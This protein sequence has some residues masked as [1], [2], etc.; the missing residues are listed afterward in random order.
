MMVFIFIG[1]NTTINAQSN[2]YESYAILNSN[3]GGNTY[4]DLK[5]NTGNT[6][7]NGANLGTFNSGSSLILNGAQNKVFKCN[8]DNITDGKLYYRIYTTTGTAGTFI[9]T[10]LFWWGPGD[11]GPGDY[12]VS[13]PPYPCNGTGQHWQ[14]SGANINVLNGLCPGDYYL[15]IYTTADFTYTGVPGFGTHKADN[16]GNNYKATFTV[17]GT[18]TV[19]PITPTLANITGQCTATATAP[20]TTDACAGTIIGTTS[21]ALTY[22]TQGTHIIHW[23]FND[24]NGQSIVVN[25]NVIIDDTVAPVTPTLADITGQCT[26][27]APIPTTTDACS[28]TI[29]GTTSDALTYS[30]QGTHIIH[31][32]FNDGNGQSIVV[33][34]NVIIDDT[35]DPVIPTLANI[36]GQCTATATAPTTTDACSGTIIGTTSDALTYSTQ[37]T[38]IIHWTFN[39]GNG[40]SIVVNQNVIIDDTVAPVT[41]TLAD[42]TGQCTAT[43]PIPTTTDACSGTIIGTTSDALTY[44]TQGTHIIHWT[45]NDGNGQSI[46]VNQNVIIDDTVKPTL[47][48]IADKNENIVTACN[49]TIPDYTSL[50]TAADNCT[51]VGS[52]SKTQSPASGT[53]ISGNNATQLITI[54]AN[55]GN[56]NTETT[57]FTI[58]LKDVTPPT[59]TCPATATANTNNDGAGNC[60]TIVSLGTPTVS[61]NCTSVGNILKTAKVGGNTI[62]PSTYLFGI[63]NTTVVWTATDQ[64]GNVSIPCNQTVTVIDNENPTIN[65]PANVQLVANAG[66]TATT[67]LVTP[68]AMDNCSVASVTND[69][70]IAFPLGNT[71]VTWTVTDTSGNKATCTQIVTVL[72][73]T[74]PTAICKNIS[75][76]LNAA[77]TASITAADINDNSTDN[78]GIASLVA[79]KTSFDCT[80]LGANSVTLTV[81]DT[82]GNVSYCTA[83]VTIVDVTLPVALCKS[84]TL[85]LNASGNAT[86]LATD[87]D[88]GSSDNCSFTRTISKSSFN[89]SNIGT[90]TVQLTI[91]DTSGNFTTCNATVTVVDPIAPVPQ[92]KNVILN[93]DAAGNA[94]LLATDIDNGSTDNCGIATRTVSPSSFTCANVGNNTVT[95]TVKDASN[96]TSTCTATVTIKDLIPPT[97]ICKAATIYLNSAGIATLTTADV[98]NGSSDNCGSVTLSLSKTSFD[99]SNRGTNTV[100]LTVTDTAGNSSTC[101][102]TVTVIDN[103]PPVA[104]CKNFTLVLAANGTGTLLPANINNGSSDNCGITSMTLSK[105]NFTCTDANGA[106][107]LVTL[108]VTDAS[109]NSSTCTA[110]VTVQTTL[111]ISSVYLETCGARF[112][113]NVSGGSGTYSYLWDVTSSTVKPFSCSLFGLGSN[114]ANCASPYY[115]FV[116]NIIH[117]A[118]LT[119]NDSNGCKVSKTFT[120]DGGAFNGSTATTNV[121]AC[122]GQ[123]ITY[124]SSAVGGTFLGIP[125]TYNYGWDVTGGT[126]ISGGGS[127]NNTVTVNWGATGVGKVSVTNTPSL[128]GSF[129]FSVDVFNVTVNPLPTPSFVT[130]IATPVCPQSPQTYTLTN[131]FATHSWTVTGGTVTAGGDPA[132]NFVTVKWG[133]GATGTVS[134]T[135]TNPV[136]SGGCSSTVSTNVAIVDIIPPT[137]TCPA[138]VT[139]NA[140]TGL[141]YATGVNLGT[142]PTGND[143]CGVASVTNNA[144]TLFPTG[145]YPV[146]VHTITWTVTD[147]KGLTANCTQTVTVT[148]NQFPVISCPT[149]VS[150]SIL[151]G[152]NRSITIVNPTTSDNCGVTK[153]TWTM[154]GA[155]VANSS[156][157]GINN[158]GTYTFNRGVTTITYT[159][160]DNS[161]KSSSCSFTVTV[162]DTIPPTITCPSNINTTTN[163]ACTATG[164]ALGTPTTADNCSV[165]SVT[166]NAPVAFPIGTTIVTWTVTDVAGNTASCTQTVTVT[167]ATPPTIACPSNI[168]TTTAVGGCTRLV[169]VP[170][171]TTADNCSVASISWIMFGATTATGINAIGNYTFNLG[172]TTVQYTVTDSAN[173]TANCSF[174][175]TVN[176]NQPPVLSCPTNSTPLCADSTGKYTKT[177][178]SWNATATD[179]C[180]T[181]SSLTYTLT[182]STTGSGTS[183]DGVAFNVGTTTVTWTATDTIGNTSNC[184]FAVNII[185]LPSITTQPISQLD[186]EGSIVNFSVVATGTG[187][188]YTWQRKL[189]TDASFITIPIESNVSYPS[190]GEIRLANVDSTLSPDGTQYQVIIT[191]SSGCSITSAAATLS[192]NKITTL[193]PI[194]TAVTQ[195]YGTNYSYTVSTSYPANVISY[196]W[197]S[198]VVS[199]VW[200]DVVNGTHFLGAQTETLQIINGTPAESAAYRVYITFDASGAD[201]NVNS[202]SRSRSITFLPEVTAPV[203]TIIQ[204]SCTVATGSVVLSGLPASGTWTLTRTGTS[205]A[206]TTGTGTS[207]TISGLATG[208]YN[209]T[210]FDGTCTS[211]PANVVINVQP[212]TP[213]VPTIDAYTLPSFADN[214]GTITLGNLPSGNWVGHQIKDGVTTTISGTGSP[215]TLTGLSNGSYEFEV[216]ELCI[217]PR[218]TPT[219]LTTVP[220]IPAVSPATNINCTGFTANWPATPTATA[221]LL[222][223]STD[224]NFATFVSGY[225]KNVGN[226]L[227]Y[228][229]TGMP[230]GPLYYRIRAKNATL[231]SLYSATVTV[232]PLINT[233]SGTWSLGTPPT[234]IGTQ[235]LVFNASFTA[236]TDLSGCSCTVNSGDVIIKSGKILTITNGVTV[237]SPGTLT[238]EDT[239]SLVQI[240]NT[241]VNIGNIN[242]IRNFTGGE[243]DYTYWSSPVALQNLQTL[244]PNTKLD[245]FFYFNS[246]LNDWMQ[247]DPSTT[248]MDA[249]KGYI[250]RGVPPPPGPPVGF[251]TNTFIGRPNNGSYSLTGVIADRSYLLGNPYPSALD[252]DTFLVANKDVLNG[253]LYFWTHNTPIAI[254]TPDPG[255]GIWAYSGNDYAVYNATGGVGAAPPDLDPNTGLPYPSQALSGGKIPTGKIAAGQGFF[256]STKGSISGT[257]I[258][259]DNAMRVGVGGIT[260][261]NSQFFKTKNPKAKTNIQL[262]KHR[263]WLDLTNVEGAF[264]QTLI[265]YVTDATNGYEDRFD[266]ESYDGNDFLDFY[267]ILQDKNLVIQGR[268]LPFDEND[269]V[270]LGYRVAVG[271]TFT[272]KIGQKDGLLSNQE[273]FIEDKLT[274]TVVNLVEENYTFT[275][276][277]GTFDDRFVLKY[278]DKTLSVEDL[279]TNDGIIA[280]YSNNYKTLIIRNNLKD[281]TVNS[282]TLYNITGQKIANWEVKGR[283]QSSIQ[284]PIKN[285]PAEIYIVKI[286]TTQG[287]FSKKIIVK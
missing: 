278:T 194:A 240:N 34:Q 81:T 281:T 276:T 239:S 255:S 170:S 245:K 227:T 283:E 243:F 233:Y 234:T 252:A 44:S 2:I 219:P 114:T 222:D 263:V 246:S 181:I 119:V 91:T 121:V 36:I 96:N 11:G 230:A 145:Q 260:G 214:D 163:T 151:T 112:V 46:V 6:D 51:A 4:Y 85:N 269:E 19:A 229:L 272:M 158:V 228:S 58:T 143:N 247:V 5:A 159:A 7:F 254:G 92:C 161:G 196:Q 199:G 264:K 41:P 191:N 265:G 285:L 29:I 198:S 287:E 137:I 62:N 211:L 253:T 122:V 187:L 280:L 53:V 192:I 150:Q 235:N 42:I 154:T 59:I 132:D 83:T 197:K 130:P 236:N 71:T 266:G 167:D 97:A 241:A 160:F 79:S 123:T 9:L 186:C 162:T 57:S 136:A 141:C 207:T 185:G 146:G 35:T 13:S 12:A 250:I 282:V 267:S 209:F 238:F 54:T 75:V 18:D 27:T 21:D 110:T 140:N 74:L 174:T 206:T 173:N 217:S 78:C 113:A 3:G 10:P 101:T 270:P 33:N 22:S 14:A 193:L 256:G 93:L 204:P 37:G 98:N 248:T 15:E 148:D 258:V 26:A 86:L 108:T 242:Y 109:G 182:G 115:R 249:G 218:S 152:C 124:T 64:N 165:V 31:W 30:T 16:G 65:C 224:S 259:Y 169:N 47:T 157:T 70:P 106:P 17:V 203:A 131:T 125:Y 52:I 118:T 201:C 215:Y 275:T 45:F 8:T 117:T 190:P 128:L 177:G 212:G 107:Q 28:G 139:V 261:N 273:I 172:I 274:N 99:C 244:S 195:C 279:E 72:D 38:H 188:T 87:I 134:V 284:I 82:S 180:S 237:N 94:T 66:C 262:E 175:V 39:D 69:A 232:T 127:S 68:T 80:N 223:V 76:N 135:V 277:A 205:S 67:V 102:A 155:T 208:T 231:I 111:T 176:D 126:I 100:T 20:T 49:F 95:L 23:T 32:T 55:D 25:Q 166:N 63:G 60:T 251:G 221:Y 189:P 268:A 50:A 171:P 210:V 105:T 48:A 1:I 77:G 129:C 88:N 153:L 149:N 200:N 73:Q 183:L 271:G 142:T 213:L 24:G 144:L 184:T 257:S 178:T 226:V 116:T 104:T 56:G 168:T 120:F 84:F 286:E 164:V 43:A 133:N 40:Q 225:P 156:P 103:T 89:C 179:G 216:V 147:Y 202:S 90:N 220:Y 61:D 138:D